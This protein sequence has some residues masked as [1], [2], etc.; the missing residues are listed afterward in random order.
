MCSSATL[1]H[2]VMGGLQELRFCELVPLLVI[3]QCAGTDANL[4]AG[5][6]QDRFMRFESPIVQT[7]ILR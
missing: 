7:G 3:G 2:K 4:V 6:P 1:P 5:E